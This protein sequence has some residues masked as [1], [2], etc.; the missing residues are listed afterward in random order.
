MRQRKDGQPEPQRNRRKTDARHRDNPDDESRRRVQPRPAEHKVHGN[1]CD[2]RRRV[3]VLMKNQRN[4]RGQQIAHH[5]APCTCQRSHQDDDE[6]SAARLLSHLRAGYGKQREAQCVRD[7]ERIRR[8]GKEVHP[9]KRYRDCGDDRVDGPGIPNPEDGVLV[10]EDIAKCAPSHRSDGCEHEDAEKIELRGYAGQRSTGGKDCHT[11]QIEQVQEQG[12]FRRL[13]VFARERSAW[14]NLPRPADVADG[15]DT[16]LLGRSGRSAPRRHPGLGRLND[17]GNQEHDPEH[18]RNH[19][20][21]AK[22]HGTDATDHIGGDGG[23]HEEAPAR[24]RGH[25]VISRAQPCP[26]MR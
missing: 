18:S 4:F 6:T 20:N 25:V 1:A 10:Q 3:D 11:K 7:E 26:G 17:S 24:Q 19:G 22:S 8:D 16:D 12:R 5:T 21:Q 14:P 15:L 9:H 13:I 23:C 2:S